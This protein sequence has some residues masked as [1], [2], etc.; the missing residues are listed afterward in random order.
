[1]KRFRKLLCYV[2]S[3]ESSSPGLTKAVE[4]ATRTGASLTLIDVLP[5]STG[6][7]WLS[8]PGNTTVDQLVIDGR[9]E[10]LAELAAE[11][12]DRGVSVAIDVVTGSPFIE[13]I[14]HVVENGHDLVIK[15]AEGTEGTFGGLL[16]T[17]ALHLM[18]K[19]PVPVWVVEPS[20][21]VTVKRVLAAVN[22][23]PDDPDGDELSTRVLQLARSLAE[24]ENAELD[25][26]H[27]WWLDVEPLLRGRRINMPPAQVDG[28]VRETRGSAERAFD[29]LVKRVDLEAVQSKL[30]LIKGKPF[31][32]INRFASKSD[33]VVLGSLSRSGLQGLL[34][35]NTAER[36]LRQIDCSVL[37]VKPKGF[38]T[39][40][41]FD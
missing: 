35:G 39:P 14:R 38:E 13:I 36:V 34:I 22:P 25:V 21:D 10:E 32:V 2:R 18:R 28:L 29:E 12:R 7:P 9:R 26:V 41:R 23:D 11:A 3:S 5:S 37:A 30:H 33:L 40:L 8:L 15:T 24:T 16:G 19:C 20:S 17:T 27:A 31:E 6:K 4:L 1:M